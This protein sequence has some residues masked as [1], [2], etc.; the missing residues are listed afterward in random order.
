MILMLTQN[1]NTRRWCHIDRMGDIP[2]V[3]FGIPRRS[4]LSG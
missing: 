2:Y 4:A 3:A 1:Y